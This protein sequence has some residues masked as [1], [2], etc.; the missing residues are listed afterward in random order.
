ME[1]MDSVNLQQLQDEIEP[2]LKEMLKNPNF[3]EVLKSTVYYKLLKF[4][5]S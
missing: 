2:L 3:I 5:S 4:S 1:S